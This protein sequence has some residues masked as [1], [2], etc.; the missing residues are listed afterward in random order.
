M[1]GP[2]GFLS[3]AVGLV[4]VVTGYIVTMVGLTT[5]YNLNGLGEQ[6]LAQTDAYVI[7]AVGIGLLVVAYVGYRGFMTF[8]T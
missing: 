8:A 3:L 1:I 2:L 6:G 4:S 5:I 7:T